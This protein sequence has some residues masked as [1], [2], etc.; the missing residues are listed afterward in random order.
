[1]RLGKYAVLACLM[2]AMGFAATHVMAAVPK[3]FI[4]FEGVSGKAPLADQQGNGFDGTLFGDATITPESKTWPTG[5]TSNGALYLNGDGY[6]KL[7]NAANINLGQKDFSISFWYRT[8]V[9]SYVAAPF[10][11]KDQDS[12]YAVN[13]KVMGMN[14]IAGRMGYDQYSVGL[15][16]HTSA[17][18][19]WSLGGTWHHVVLTQ[20]SRSAYYPA[21]GSP[22]QAAS[23]TV[24]L[25]VDGGPLATGTAAPGFP[26]PGSR[27]FNTS[28]STYL[29]SGIPLPMSFNIGRGSTASSTYTNSP[30]GPNNFVGWIDEF[31][32][33]D[34]C[35]TQNDVWQEFRTNTSGVTSVSLTLQ[36]G[37]LG[38]VAGK[39]VTFPSINPVM[40]SQKPWLGM[41]AYT[42][43]T[44][45]LKNNNA[46][47]SGTLEFVRQGAVTTTETA[48]L[49]GI[50]L[51]GPGAARFKIN[52]ITP[53]PVTGGLF[54]ITKGLPGQSSMTIQIIFTPTAAEYDSRAGGS[55]PNKYATLSLYTNINGVPK[56]DIQLVGQVVPVGLSSFSTQ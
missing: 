32:Y 2:M 47:N 33:F 40:A 6:V 27:E 35:L 19:T 4:K 49:P 46:L 48:T 50:M 29:D 30:W 20:R 1:M 51:T 37:S 28:S 14:G 53:D 34:V 45:S 38:T 16:N 44:L 39:T 42:T 24:A 11:S 54:N 52:K 55:D 8:P 22:A 3:A 56:Y 25:Y 26:V 31:K 7:A 36:A 15:A 10:W 5:V 23:D 18:T 9:G 41:P 43:V 17:K 21:T 13:T 12:A